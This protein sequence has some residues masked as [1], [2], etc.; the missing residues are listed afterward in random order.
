LGL[1]RSYGPDAANVLFHVVNERHLKKRSMV[2]TTNKPPSAWGRVPR[3]ED[4]AA[5]IV[6]RVLELGRLLHLDG[7][8][9][10]TRHVP[11]QSLRMRAAIRKKIAFLNHVLKKKR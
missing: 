2:F 9:L 6:D 5:A 7:P 1:C 11:L 3:D 10:R 8:S 4:L